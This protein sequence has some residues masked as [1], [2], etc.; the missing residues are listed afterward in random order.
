MRR[1]LMGQRLSLR[2]SAGYS[3]PCKHRLPASNLRE[4][5]RDLFAGLFAG[6]FNRLA[7]LLE[8]AED[9]GEVFL[10]QCP[11]RG[12][13]AKVAET[14]WQATGVSFRMRVASGSGHNQ[15]DTDRGGG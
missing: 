5:V 1:G 4:F 3:L 6:A 14:G 9:A 12:A 11:A 10:G 7:V 13:L 8:D 15:T 2:R